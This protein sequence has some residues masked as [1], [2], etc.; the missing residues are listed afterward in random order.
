[1]SDMGPDHLDTRTAAAWLDN[2][3]EATGR[4]A[5]AAHLA[6]CA[7]CRA[8]LCAAA[9]LVLPRYP[10]YGVAGAGLVAAAAVVLML[11]PGRPVKPDWRD[12]GATGATMLAPSGA[13]TL[14]LKFR[15]TAV[16]GADRYRVRVFEPS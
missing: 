16:A 4:E 15:W 6:E 9:P 3:L 14:P 10:V 5:V 1:M 2:G 7:G 13:A 12:P 11:L 8:E